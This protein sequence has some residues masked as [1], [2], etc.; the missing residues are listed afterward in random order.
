MPDSRISALVI[1]IAA[2]VLFIF[3]PA[4][5]MLVALGAAVAIVALRVM[6]PLDAFQTIN[7]NVIGIFVGNLIVADALIR[8]RAP[9][10]LAEVIVERSR[11]TA[12]ALLWICLL[13]GA[14]SA[15]VDNVATV[16]L[17]APVGLALAHKLKLNPKPLMIG[18]A[19]SSNLQGAA[20][21]IGDTPSMLLGTEAG[22]NFVEFFWLQGKPGIFF[23]VQCGAAASFFVLYVLFRKLREKVRIERVEQVKSWVPS[24][25]LTGLILTLASTSFIKNRPD[26]TPGAICMVAGIVAMAWEKLTHKGSII[27]GLKSLDWDTTFFL[28]G[29]FILVGSISATGW[30]TDIAN[31]LLGMV[32]GNVF[33]AYTLIVVIS[34]LVSAVVDN[35]P[36]LAAMLPAVGLMSQ[37]LGC[38]PMLLYFGLLIGASLGGNVTQIGAS[39]NI[40]ACAMAKK[41]GHPIGFFEFMKIGVPFTLAATLAAY[42]FTWFVWR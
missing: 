7:W 39:A 6:P 25:I 21:L 24:L 15:F 19:I 20:T 32:G 26:W 5:R 42:L 17:I 22:I 37:N 30:V 2:Y 33:A 8:S 18:I 13:T 28:M 9:A 16:L 23:A 40:A 41:D 1:F 3:L 31:A 14:I 27:R 12:W 36:Y 4:R 11:N 34:V 10:Y 38:N 29:I 35:I